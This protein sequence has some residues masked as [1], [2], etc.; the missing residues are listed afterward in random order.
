MQISFS[1]CEN[2]SNECTSDIFC[3]ELLT[4]CHHE[5]KMQYI[6]STLSFVICN[7][8]STVTKNSRVHFQMKDGAGFSPAESE[9]T[10][11]LIVSHGTQ[12]N[13]QKTERR[14][15]MVFGL[16]GDFYHKENGWTPRPSTPSGWFRA[17][18][19]RGKRGHANNVFLDFYEVPRL[20]ERETLIHGSVPR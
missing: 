12:L 18:S 7:N 9:Q 11:K 14:R 16:G 20:R 17:S 8:L 10:N 15:R 13:K 2:T 3:E 1:S 4:K 5:N 6:S 19:T